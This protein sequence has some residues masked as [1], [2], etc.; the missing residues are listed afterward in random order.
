VH[1]RL[2]GL[3][4][5]DNSR[6]IYAGSSDD[7]ALNAGVQRFTADPEAVARLAYDADLSGLI[8]LPTV[9]LHALHDPVVSFEAEA[10][11]AATIA[12]ARRS[13]LLVQTATDEE[14]HSKLSDSEYV[15]ILQALEGWLDTGR[16]PSP[17][18]IAERCTANLPTYG[19]GC[20]FVLTPPS[21]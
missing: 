17:A 6:V 14:Q 18:D 11:Y 2:G 15:A 1:E 19:Q 5:F 20:H 21:R 9:T 3:N 8:V 10:Q 7:E 12:A 4:P 13:H 16:R